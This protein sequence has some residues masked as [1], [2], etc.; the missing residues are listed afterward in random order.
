MSYSYAPKKGY[1]RCCYCGKSC[2]ITRSGLLRSHKI[3]GTED[4]CVRDYPEY[5]MRERDGINRW[6]KADIHFILQGEPE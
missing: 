5:V 6:V 1:G 2:A 3:P 4:D